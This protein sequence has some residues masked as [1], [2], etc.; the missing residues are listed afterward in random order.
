[1][2]PSS[3]ILWHIVKH[4]KSA[5]QKKERL[6]Y[7]N[8]HIIHSRTGHQYQGKRHTLL[9]RRNKFKALSVSHI[10]FYKYQLPLKEVKN[11]P[12]YFQEDKYKQLWRHINIYCAQENK[13]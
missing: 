10:S 4:L 6:I 7:K 1:M 5:L 2:V 3:K 11:F 13:T 9:I 12:R 8:I